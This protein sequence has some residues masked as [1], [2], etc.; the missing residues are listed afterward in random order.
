MPAFALPLSPKASAGGT[1]IRN[2]EPTCWPIRPLIRPGISVVDARS[3][4]TLSLP[5]L[6][7]ICLPFVPLNRAKA[8][9]ILLDLESLAPLPGVMTLVVV[10]FTLTGVALNVTAGTLSVPPTVTTSRPLSAGTSLSVEVQ[11][12]RTTRDRRTADT[13][14]TRDG[15]MRAPTSGCGKDVDD[16]HHGVLG[17]DR[18]GAPGA[19]PIRRRHHQQ[20]AAADGLID[21]ALVPTR[22]D[23]AGADLNV[24]RGAVVAGGVKLLAVLPQ[25]SG[26][27]DLDRLAGLDHRT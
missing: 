4:R 1:P 20:D 13:I 11:P 3:V 22:D 10:S 7:L 25:H 23:L 19:V 17:S 16:E 21:Q 24:H 15:R 6:L 27:A 2:R 5:K 12:A 18:R 14:R 8:I 26:V 9:T